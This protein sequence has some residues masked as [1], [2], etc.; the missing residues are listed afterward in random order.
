MHFS[1]QKKELFSIRKHSSSPGVYLIFYTLQGPNYKLEIHDDKLKL[2]KR[3]WW[4]LFSSKNDIIE[5]QLSE[6]SQFQITVPKFIWGKLDLATFDGKKNSFRFS[7]N[8][9]MMEKIEKYVHKLII[10][11]HQRRQDTLSQKGK[12]KEKRKL[13]LAA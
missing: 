7:T 5:W 11:N 6:L 9:I 3:S 1:F 8:S 2:I 12:G 10:K 4:S 13:A